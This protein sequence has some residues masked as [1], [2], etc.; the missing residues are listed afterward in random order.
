VAPARVTDPTPALHPHTSAATSSRA[1]GL[2]HR[3]N[4]FILVQMPHPVAVQGIL[5]S[6]AADRPRR[7]AKFIPMFLMGSPGGLTA[8]PAA[9]KILP[10]SYRP[11]TDDGGAGRG[12]PPRTCR[13]QACHAVMG[14]MNIILFFFNK[15][16]ITIILRYLGVIIPQFCATQKGAKRR[17]NSGRPLRKQGIIEM[18]PW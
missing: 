1:A 16:P 15:Q 7:L 11:L 10:R 18:I 5:P 3:I 17:S 4:T 2:R 14:R 6:P 13:G 9:R 12:C 8:A